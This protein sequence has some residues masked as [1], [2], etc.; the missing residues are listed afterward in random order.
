MIEFVDP[1]AEPSVAMEA[2]TLS[3][4]PNEGPISIG[5]LANGFPDS[6]AFLNRV[7]AALQQKLPQAEFQHYDK[8]DPSSVVS[9][10][11]LDTIVGECDAVV[12]AYGH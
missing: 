9:D 8:G 12:A 3:I 5:L 6:V 4:D 1:R 10:E 7:E 2:Y 11:M